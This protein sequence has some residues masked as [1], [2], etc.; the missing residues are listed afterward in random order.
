MIDMPN[1]VPVVSK[2]DLENRDTKIME[3]DRDYSSA[4]GKMWHEVGRKG[5]ESLT[6]LLSVHVGRSRF[7]SSDGKYLLVSNRALH[8]LYMTEP[9]ANALREHLVDNIDELLLE[10]QNENERTHGKDVTVHYS[11]GISKAESELTKFEN[12]IIKNAPP[13]GRVSVT[14]E[15]LKRKGKINSVWWVVKYDSYPSLSGSQL[16]RR[17]FS[18]LGLRVSEVIRLKLND[19]DWSEGRLII[20]AGNSSGAKPTTVAC[21]RGGSGSL[22]SCKQHPSIQNFRDLL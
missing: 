10:K 20:R 7:S 22:L 21:T 15:F 16:L 19:I 1:N 3:G 11:P 4:E 6:G 17:L 5:F 2:D 12:D 9:Q 18:E 13:K 14:R 8:L